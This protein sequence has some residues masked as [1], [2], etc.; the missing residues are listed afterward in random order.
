M[1][2]WDGNIPW[3]AFLLRYSVEPV[4]RAA[5]ALTMCCFLRSGPHC[6]AAGATCEV[7]GG[8]EEAQPAGGGTCDAD[9]HLFAFSR[10]CASD[11]VEEGTAV[12]NCA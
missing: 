2:K 10:Y 11:C 5:Q 4:E 7:P 3:R 8:P 9:G 1:S 6:G 12:M